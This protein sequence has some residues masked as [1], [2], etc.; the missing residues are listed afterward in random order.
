[1]ATSLIN[2]VTSGQVLTGA[3]QT[4][5][6]V[7]R[8]FYDYS[9]G[10]KTISAKLNSNILCCKVTVSDWHIRLSQLS[11]STVKNDNRRADQPMGGN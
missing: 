3:Q 1:M 5:T 10:S 2:S 8:K 7:G 9:N 11:P 6:V 4:L